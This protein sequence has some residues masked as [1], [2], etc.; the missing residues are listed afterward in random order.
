MWVK[1]PCVFSLSILAAAATACIR[2]STKK[3]FFL[4]CCFK[5]KLRSN[6]LIGI[7]KRRANGQK[8]YNF[9]P[10]QFFFLWG[11]GGPWV[12]F[13]ATAWISLLSLWSPEVTLGSV[14]GV[15][16]VLSMH[17]LWAGGAENVA[18]PSFL[19]ANVFSFFYLHVSVWS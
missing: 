9:F 19:W 8:S 16:R 13:P 1:S 15:N 3:T 14:R 18:G 12:Q 11:R 7:D 5:Y 10:G 17:D 4:P 6:C 2:A